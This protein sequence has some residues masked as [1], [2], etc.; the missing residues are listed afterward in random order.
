[1]NNENLI[2]KKFEKASFLDDDSIS[3]FEKRSFNFFERHI[4]GNIFI[5]YTLLFSINEYILLYILFD[6]YLFFLKKNIK[7]EENEFTNIQISKYFFFR[8]ISIIFIF[9]IKS[10]FNHN[11]KKRLI[12]FFSNFKKNTHFFIYVIFMFLIWIAILEI[13][14]AILIS[15][16][17]IILKSK[18]FYRLISQIIKG[19]PVKQFQNI[20]LLLFF[21]FL[22]F[23]IIEKSEMYLSMVFFIL[24]G[25]LFF[26]NEDVVSRRFF[27]SDLI[28]LHHLTFFIIFLYHF[29]LA[30]IFFQKNSLHF[31]QFDIYLG[32]FTILFGFLKYYFYQKLKNITPD[33]SPIFY[34]ESTILYTASFAFVIDFIRKSKHNYKLHFIITGFGLLVLYYHN[35]NYII[36]LFKFKKKSPSDENTDFVLKELK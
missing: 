31:D 11:P 26:L 22:I 9:I 27:C 18:Y 17:L 8:T 2:E 19:Y 7:D 32:I 25:F 15:S 29:V 36:K 10:H 13:G 16:I 34:K 3:Y 30:L 23:N 33:N 28:L 5:F 21:I 35:K 12:S 20:F 4:Q 6:K 1:M 24:A 14:N